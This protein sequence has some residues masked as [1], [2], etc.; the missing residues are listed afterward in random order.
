LKILQENPFNN[1]LKTHKLHGF[2]SN[3][4]SASIN[5]EFRIIFALR[6]IEGVESIIL[7][8]IGTHEEVY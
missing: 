2:L 5:Y 7:I 6:E 8:D 1:K 4:H 3:L